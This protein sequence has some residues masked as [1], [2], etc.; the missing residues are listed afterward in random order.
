MTTQQPWTAAGRATLR[1]FT[2][3]DPD[4]IDADYIR[5]RILAIEA[6][7][8][9][10]LRAALEQLHKWLG[11]PGVALPPHP[12]ELEWARQLIKGSLAHSNS[13]GCG[14]SATPGGPSHL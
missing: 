4:L 11:P 10:P 8:A 3:F 6:Q 12:T 5:K 14:G 1:W 13:V 7:A 2:A 9:E